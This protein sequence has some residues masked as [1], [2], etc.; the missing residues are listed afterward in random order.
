MKNL[1][2]PGLPRIL[3]ID[4]EEGIREGLRSMLQAEGVAVE[5]R[6]VFRSVHCK[7]ILNA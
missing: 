7:A 5:D 2:F 3:V 1:N 6:G 4:D